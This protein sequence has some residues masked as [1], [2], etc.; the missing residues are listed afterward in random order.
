[1]S[2]FWKMYEEVKEA[3][4]KNAP[5]Q[6][7]NEQLKNQPKDPEQSQQAD[8]PLELEDD[9]GGSDVEKEGEDIDGSTSDTDL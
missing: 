6:I 4:R 2:S 1:M 9:I 8:K 3:E 7:I 5:P